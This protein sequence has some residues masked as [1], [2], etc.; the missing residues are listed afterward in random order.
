M[1][2]F[3]EDKR[4]LQKNEKKQFILNGII[5]IDICK[6]TT[7]QQNNPDEKVQLTFKQYN[8]L[9]D[10]TF[11][12]FE[13]ALFD[14][15]PD[16]AIFF[17]PTPYDAV[18]ASL[19]LLK[20]LVHF[21]EEENFL[22][23]PIFARIG[24]HQIGEKEKKNLLQTKQ[25]N[26][27][28]TTPNDQLTIAGKLQ[29]N[30]PI[31]RIAMS[32]EVYE[33]IDNLRDLFRPSLITPE[34]VTGAKSFVLAN[35]TIM[36][37]ERELFEGLPEQQMKLIPPIVCLDFT[38]NS[39]TNL[40]RLREF[41]SKKVL[42]VLGETKPYPESPIPSAA[43]SDAV[44]IMEVMAKFGANS[45]T[46]VG[47]GGWEDTADL[48][49]ER[50]VLVVGG[51]SNLYSFAINGL[52]DSISGKLEKHC[53]IG[54]VHFVK[55]K[56]RMF[57]Q[58]MATSTT[59]IEFFGHH[60]NYPIDSA[61]VL[62]TRNPFSLDE[63][64]KRTLLWVAGITG[65]GTQAAARFVWELVGSRDAQEVFSRRSGGNLTS[66]PIACV[67]APDIPQEWGRWRILEYKILWAVDKDG[68]SIC[69]GRDGSSLLRREKKP[70]NV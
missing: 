8:S 58:I 27:P 44:G 64:E 24:V 38:P 16:G 15:T 26:E 23:R 19:K 32:S 18:Q 45:E 47:I 22:D 21:N 14:R 62:I 51:I 31:G 55:A 13:S 49:S 52:F 12:N 60:T 50:N 29:K 59:G 69:P 33:K 57:N 35:R 41:F 46:S 66:P 28:N 20:N 36:G 63:E 67:I 43:T 7:L 37:Y 53:S 68:C 2:R 65:K 17:F 25:D 4:R 5:D 10:N 42:V 6:S 70:S 54:R 48:A 9:V 56:G 40:T 11:K 61:I 3:R 39:E 30:C 1:L 34:G